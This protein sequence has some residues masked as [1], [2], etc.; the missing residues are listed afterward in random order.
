MATFHKSEKLS[1]LDVLSCLEKQSIAVF[2]P[3]EFRRMFHVSHPQAKYF[4]ETYA[5]RGVFTRL[6]RGLYGV[7]RALPGD[8][9]LANILYRPSYLSFEYALSKYSIIP[10]AVYS[11]TSATPMQTKMFVATGRTFTYHSVKKAAFTGYHLL[12]EGRKRILI[13]EPEKALVD[14]LYFV[15]TGKKHLNDR[16]DCRELDRKKL[17]SYARLYRRPSLM[18]LIE[19]VCFPKK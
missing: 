13:A 2:S 10:E 8:E 5:K 14:Y 4:L 7:S 1:I 12:K 6:K 11:L 3:I 16:I 17:M 19:T 18:V 9:E 15:A